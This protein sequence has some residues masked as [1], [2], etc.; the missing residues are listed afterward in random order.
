MAKELKRKNTVFVAPSNIVQVV[1]SKKDNFGLSDDERTVLVY[2]RDH[3]GIV[4]DARVKNEVKAD[5]DVY[6]CIETLVRF[7]YAKKE[8][9]K[10]ILTN[11]GEYV[12]QAFRME[13][14]SYK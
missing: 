8:R 5:S 12:A 4:P 6:E 11:N 1:G 2:V 13:N 10:V 9:N 7:N 14:I 3:G